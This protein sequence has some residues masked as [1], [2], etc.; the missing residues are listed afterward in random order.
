MDEF[1]HI[2]P[3]FEQALR[4][5]E[6]EIMRFLMRST[7]D[8]EDAL[9]LFQETWLRAYRAYPRLDSAAGLR[10]WLY[11]IATNLCLNRTRARV[12]RSRVI[13]DDPMPDEPQSAAAAH[14][15]SASQDGVIHL[16]AAI[17]RL[18]RKQR[19]ALI[20]RKFGG[21]EYHEIALA[22]ECSCESARAGVYQALKK[23]KAMLE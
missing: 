21:L 16:R 4:L 23:L 14:T 11:R 15:N 22:L 3:P 10:P 17:E 13:A 7:R 1:A 6:A 20:M 8:H 18:P 9:D 2:P 5:H 19:S 12:R